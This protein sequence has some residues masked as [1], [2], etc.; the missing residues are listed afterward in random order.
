MKRGL[1]ILLLTLAGGVTLADVPATAK[2]ADTS[3][4]ETHTF[5]REF[6]NHDGSTYAF[7]NPLT[8][9]PYA[10]TVNV[11]HTENLRG[12][13]RVQVT[14]SGAQPSAGRAADPYGAN[15]LNQEYPV[16]VMQ[17]RGQGEQVTPE[18][19]WTSSVTQRSQVG[20]SA[21]A[22]VWTQDRYADGADRG[23]LS[24]LD[25]MPDAADCPSIDQSGLLYTHLTPF[26]AA[27]GKVYSACDAA[28][29]PPEAAVDSA[30]PPAEI[31]AFSDAEGN[32]SLQFEVRSDTEN[33]SLGCNQDTPCS[34]VVIPITGISCD[35]ASAEQD[36][37]LEPI[38]QVCR[39]TG[40]FE[41]GS[42]NLLG[43]PDAA[44]SPA[45]WWSASNWRNR[46]VVPITFGPPPDVCDLLD[47]RAPTGFYGS[48][49][50]A[51]AAL[52]WSPAY[53]LNKKRFKFQLNQ[54]PDEAG[55][56][57]MSGGGG[58]AAEVSSARKSTGDPI[59]YAP[60]A[61]TGFAVGYVIDRP[62]N[63]GEYGELRLNARL[64][65]KLMTL[66]YA[67][68]TFGAQHP[69]MEKNPW[70]IMSDPEFIRLNPGLDTVPQEAGA[71]LL[72]LS[73][74]S[75]II[76]QLT[77]YIAQDK[78]A[79]AFIKGKPDPW[80]MKVNPSYKK[81]KLPIGEWPLLDTFIPTGSTQCQLANP[82]I[83]FNNIAAPVTTLRKI[84]DALLDGWPNL[85]TSCVTDIS[86]DPPT[87][88]VGRVARQP[89]GS[90]F[91][92]GIVSLG[93]AAR[94]G[95]R[96]AALQ[97]KRNRFVAPSERSMAAAVKLMTPAKAK[98]GPFVL[99]QAK[100]KR[101]ARAYPGTMVV[102]T[103]ARTR[104]LEKADAAKVAQ[105]IRVS[106]T[107]GQKQGSGNGQLPGGFLPIRKTGVT[108]RLYAAA[109]RAADV[110]EAQ[111]VPAP[112]APPV[113]PTPTIETPASVTPVDVPEVEVPIEQPSPTAEAQPEAAEMPP[114]QAVSSEL[115]GQL[116]PLLLG[117]GLAAG[118]ATSVVR[119]V[120]VPL[121]R[122]R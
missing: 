90:R 39:K 101:S 46:F 15:G 113:V 73:N 36:Y 8:G 66:S 33:E 120:V 68:S 11:D 60:T 108:G 109:A 13:E 18:T 114:T 64:L 88:K 92:L 38:E 20:V 75:D 70:G 116:L 83:Y 93:D 82:A 35:Q 110:I 69:G 121:R 31:A 100:V 41:P 56:Q 118:L 99:D 40:Q 63:S 96:T 111:R 102:Y 77:S 112:P 21:S 32:G 97:T 34:I 59:A 80:G 62:G 71:A 107:E 47:K 122:R 86:T 115:G 89:Y 91:V 94:Y 78:D 98:N 7:D 74:S 81:I 1:L 22:A 27:S 106:T 65:A 57:L 4:H 23:V 58:A 53:C 52:Q 16:V 5:A 25:P 84:A 105:F 6:V 85:Q 29:M 30:F 72:N 37:D 104:N 54:M 43:A 95:L 79:M 87:Y 9:Q 2:V 48:E 28:H 55:F 76:E 49:L 117:L 45:Y 61:V 67:G 24:G 42:S 44:V 3:W 17:C 12:R 14:W 51:Q 26:V 50:L 19:C 10:M 119:L 103:A